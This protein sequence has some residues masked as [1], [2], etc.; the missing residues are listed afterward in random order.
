MPLVILVGGRLTSGKDT[1]ADHLVAAHGFVKLGMSDT[2]AEALYRLDP[3]IPI[4]ETPQGRE[5]LRYQR[6]VDQVGYV[7]A[8]KN[9]E[10]RRLLQ[11]LGTEVGRQLLGQ[12][13]WV[14]A[15]KKKI[16]ELTS[17]GKDVVITGI[18]FPNELRLGY[19]LSNNHS[20][21]AASVWV[22]RPSVE[23][24][25]ST[26]AS[27]GSVSADDFEYVLTNDKDLK[28]LYTATD[29]LLDTIRTDYV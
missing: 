25:N 23:Q 7:Q 3:W 24:G 20:T 22:T 15:A 16:L 2:L 1:F 12:N 17:A 11:I 18:R 10:V 8:K 29:A 13:I 28:S 14:D 21:P 5:L 9:P 4:L 19:D 27:E 26:H 6:I